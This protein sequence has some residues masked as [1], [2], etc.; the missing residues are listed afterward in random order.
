M[1]RFQRVPWGT[2]FVKFNN[3]LWTLAVIAILAGGLC[4]AKKPESA[5]A[6]GKPVV[7]T[8]FYPVKY[9]AERIGGD[10]VKVVCPVPAD[11]DAIFWKP[12]EKT[13]SA[14]QK[15]DLIILNGAEFA[16]WVGKVSLPE[17]KVVNTAKPFEKNFIN[18]KNAV[19][20]SH[21]PAG[22]HTHKGIDGHTWLDP[23]N[24]KT[25]AE[26]IRKA[27][28]KH[29]PKHKE[30]FEKNFAALAADLDG[31]KRSLLELSGTYDDKPMFCS[32]PAYNYIGRRFKWNISN[33]DLDPEEM[34]GD[35]TFAEIKKAKKDFP[36]KYILWEAFPKKEI[37]ERFKKELGLESIEFSPCELLDEETLKKG[38]DYLSVMKQ[39]IKNITPIFTK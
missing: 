24:A 26:E 25:Q 5:K 12:D 19:T 11:E 27:L 1:A 7:Y 32:H 10:A 36:A 38:T 2:R 15:A 37:A 31:L 8:A 6:D 23:V 29:F 4:C 34:P 3:V 9:F 39:N 22:T 18:F 14:F 17:A 21:G 28:V 30:A 33:L 20:H 35:E 13:L 16:K